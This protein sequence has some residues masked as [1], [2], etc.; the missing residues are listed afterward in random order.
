M[1]LA[2]AYLFLLSLLFAFV[3]IEL[4]GKYGWAERQPTWYRASGFVRSLLAGRKPLTGYHLFMNLFLI[5]V[6]HLPFFAGMAWSP[7]AE[8]LLLAFAMI[9]FLVEDFLWFVFNPAYGVRNFRKEKVWWHATSVWVLGLFPLDY[10][11]GIVFSSAL[12]LLADFL[13]GDM[14]LFIGW[15]E[16]LGVILALV[17]LSS[18]FAPLY[19]RWYRT[20]R[21][22]DD[23]P[24]AGIFH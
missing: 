8:L 7:A 3:E 4:E 20:M 6:F 11:S 17:F 14:S 22:H 23:R 15:L 13:K 19:A 24:K 5:A 21:K 1:L 16:T 2:A 18:L 10:V 9:F 12:V